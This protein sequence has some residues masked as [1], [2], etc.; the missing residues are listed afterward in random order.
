M[1][2]MIIKKNVI[3]VELAVNIFKQG[4]TYIADCP[5]LAL[6]THGKTIKEVKKCFEEALELW[7]EVTLDKKILK[8]AL[9]ALGWKIEK[10]SDGKFLPKPDDVSFKKV[11]IELLAQKYYSLPIP[12][13]AIS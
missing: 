13:S 10:L 12:Y 5:A 7:V 3:V 11:P 1:S 9:L 2:K 8:K 4:K 6:S